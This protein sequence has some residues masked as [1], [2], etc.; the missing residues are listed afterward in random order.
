MP[1]VGRQLGRDIFQVCLHTQHRQER[2]V[3]RLQESFRNRFT[4]GSAISTPDNGR[5]HQAR[6]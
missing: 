5:R 2:R 1:D 4:V 6:A 3:I